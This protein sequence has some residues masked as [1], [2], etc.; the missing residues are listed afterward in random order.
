MPLLFV[1]GVICGTLLSFVWW[2]FFF[3]LLAGLCLYFACDLLASLMAAKEHGW[4]FL[5]PLFIMF[6]SVHIS[7][8]CGTIV[9]LLNGKKLR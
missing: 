2:P 6:F 9:G 4:K 1:V 3:A 5:L 8:G 7:Y